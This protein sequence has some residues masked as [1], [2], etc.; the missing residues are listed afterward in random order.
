M[1]V[2]VW[3]VFECFCA[4]VAKGGVV[5]GVA[6]FD[7]GFA[8]GVVELMAEESVILNGVDDARLGAVCG[9]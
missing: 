9:A 3:C 2:C 5:E 6:C 8:C 7:D 4:D 1:L